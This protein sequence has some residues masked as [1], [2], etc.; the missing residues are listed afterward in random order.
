MELKSIE[1]LRGKSIIYTVD[2]EDGFFALG[3]GDGLADEIQ[4]EVNGEYMSTE[5]AVHMLQGLNDD[6]WN[7]CIENKATIQ[8]YI[9]FFYL[10]RPLFDDG[11][12]VQ[13]GDKVFISR[14]E[15]MSVN[16]LIYDK[17]GNIAPTGKIATDNY[18]VKYNSYRRA[19]RPPMPDT[20]ERIDHDA[21]MNPAHYC[22][23]HGLN[24]PDDSDQ[25]ECT[26]AMMRHLLK[27]QR[28]LD[29]RGDA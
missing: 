26:E 28:E 22:G 16:A 6:L 12:P 14:E 2:K 24:L 29:A 19:K 10:P 15:G 5:E 13:W 4:A 1:K 18:Y 11:E 9:N 23:L 7:W 8:D 3:S 17:D 20:Q 21:T 27:R 25:A